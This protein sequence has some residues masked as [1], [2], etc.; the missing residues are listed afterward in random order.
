MGHSNRS[1]VPELSRHSMCRILP[2]TAIRCT[3]K[4]LSRNKI[5]LLSVGSSRIDTRSL[6]KKTYLPIEMEINQDAQDDIIRGLQ[7]GSVIAVSDGSFK[8]E[9]GTGAFKAFNV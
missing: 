6:Q 5:K 4:M 9:F 8:S 7:T 1:L 2:Q 3:V